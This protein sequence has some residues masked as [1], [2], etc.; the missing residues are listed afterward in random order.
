MVDCAPEPVAVNIL[1]V[2]L[3]GTLVATD[4]LW[5]ALLLAISAN[6]LVLLQL[7]RWMTR[8]R[9][10]VKRALAQRVTPDPERLPYNEEV[11]VFLRQEKRHGRT[12]VLAT[13]SDAIWAHAIAQ[14]VGIFDDVLASTGQRNLKGA[15]K[16]KAITAYCQAH[17]FG[18]FAYIG[19]AIADLPI[20]EQA[21]RQYVVGPSHRL[22]TALG[23]R[24]LPVTI[25]RGQRSRFGSLL[26]LF[27]R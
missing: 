18:T 6:P 17:S 21:A 3:D 12:L 8:G 4:V 16:L 13:A 2:D 11:L 24:K 23:K 1:F 22:L 14:H 20:W 25:L 7:P 27:G 10:A 15:E 9:A 5:E 26:R 19:D